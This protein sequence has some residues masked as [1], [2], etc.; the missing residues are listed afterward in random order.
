MF[1]Q[2]CG[3]EVSG[4]N[5][6]CPNCGAK[7]EKDTDTRQINDRVLQKLSTIPKRYYLAILCQIISIFLVGSSMFQ[8]SAKMFTS[9]TYKITLFEGKDMWKALFIFGYLAT[10]LSMAPPIFVNWSW[11]RWNFIPGIVMPI[12]ALIWMFSAFIMALNRVDLGAYMELADALDI[13][14]TLTANAW[15]FML[16][17]VGGAAFSYL[18]MKELMHENNVGKRIQPNQKTKAKLVGVASVPMEKARNGRDIQL[19]FELMDGSKLTLFEKSE[20]QAQLGDEGILTWND[21]MV[22]FFEKEDM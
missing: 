11:K 19:T 16:S 12:A 18:S 4:S 7:I 21:D 8:V 10:V 22:V 17:S 1:C 13:S 15:I 9:Y 2:K 20:Y 6:Y 3:K 14:A 5:G